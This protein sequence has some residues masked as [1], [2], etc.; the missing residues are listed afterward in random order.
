MYFRWFQVWD[1]ENID[2]ADVTDTASIFEIDCMNELHVGNGVRL[3]SIVKAIN[4]EDPVW[5]AQV[6]KSELRMSFISTV[7]TKKNF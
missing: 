5:F 2:T 4:S 6:C 1:F 7:I 3:K